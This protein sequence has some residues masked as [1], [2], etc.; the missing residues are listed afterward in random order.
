[1]GSAS[2]PED[3]VALNVAASKT[4][5]TP[6]LPPDQSTNF[7]SSMLASSKSAQP[8]PRET[9]DAKSIVEASESKVAPVSIDFFGT[10]AFGH[11]FVFV[12]DISYSMDARG[13]ERF[14]RAVEELLRSVS[15]LRSNQSY[16]VFL[17][18]WST[19]PIFYDSTHQYVPAVPG[20]AKKLRRWLQDVRLGPGTDPRR[21]LSLAREMNPDAIFLL[22]DGHFNQPRTPKSDTGWMDSQGTRF[23]IDVQDGIE[24]FFRDLPIHTIAFENAFT[25]TAMDAIAGVSGGQSRY[26]KTQSL[27]PFDSQRLVTVLQQMDQRR[28]EGLPKQ[29]EYQTRLSQAREF[30][31][32]GELVFAEYLIRPLR[33]AE[34]SM[35]LNPVLLSQVVEILDRELQ[36]A[37]LEDFDPIAGLHESQS[38][39]P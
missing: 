6:E 14:D 33:D 7:A 32:E 27:V 39:A 34:E 12:L 24:T 31:A 1:M 21:A 28:A 4:P 26:V 22:S 35:I 9:M 3:S 16:F 18:C 10:R 36:G 38:P 13:G 5:A 23:Q 11:R 19:Q 8:V 37:R 29:Q 15:Q 30:I 20:H 17:F 25:S 2:G